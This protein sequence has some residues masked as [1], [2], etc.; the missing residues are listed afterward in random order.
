[1][2]EAATLMIE[3]IENRLAQLILSIEAIQP[4]ADAY[5]AADRLDKDPFLF[6]TVY[7]GL[8][9]A[10]VVRIGTL[11]DRSR[12]VASLPKLRKHL[13]KGS[14]PHVRGVA[15]LIDAPESAEWKR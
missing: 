7:D 3:K 11:W 1:M 2:S 9:D 10:A 6:G 4:L 13:V 5:R 8:W 15:R 12:G 14:E